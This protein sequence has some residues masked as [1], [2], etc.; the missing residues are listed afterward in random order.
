M[1]FVH[2][3]LIS[4][5]WKKLAEFYI[6]VFDCKPILPERNLNGK[7]LDEAT[8]IENANITGTHLRLPGFEEGSPTLEIFQFDKNVKHPERKLNTEGIAHMAFRVEDV[9][10]VLKEILFYGG[11][12]IGKVT[13][14]TIKDVGTITF[15]YAADPEGNIIEVQNW[16]S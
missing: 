15:V 6:K 5:N 2:L 16:S 14:K 1:K 12:Q 13:K 9:D 4:N 8:A 7:W 11:S 3:N 10:Y